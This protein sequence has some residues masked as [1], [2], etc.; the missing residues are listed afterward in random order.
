VGKKIQGPHPPL[1][2]RACSISRMGD[3]KITF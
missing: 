3:E 1:L 2:E